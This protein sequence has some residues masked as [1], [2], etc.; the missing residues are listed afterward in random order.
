ML[1]GARRAAY[2]AVSILASVVLLAATGA[3]LSAQERTGW[4]HT[5]YVDPPRG[6]RPPPPLYGLVDAQGRFTRLVV[7][8]AALRAAGAH[9]R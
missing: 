5:V 3:S 7:D 1:S 9:A 4:F 8:D 2:V 6:Q